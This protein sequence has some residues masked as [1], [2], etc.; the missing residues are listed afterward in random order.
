LLTTLINGYLV[1]VQPEVQQSGRAIW[2]KVKFT[3]NGEERTGW[4]IQTLLIT[5]TPVADWQPTAAP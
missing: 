2:V 4:I 3:L 1:E 5:A